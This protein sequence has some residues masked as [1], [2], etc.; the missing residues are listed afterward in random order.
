MISCGFFLG[1]CYSFF[2]LNSFP[3]TGQIHAHY[4]SIKGLTPAQRRRW[5]A[6]RRNAYRRFGL[7]AITSEVVP[8]LGMVFACANRVAYVILSFCFRLVGALVRVVDLGSFIRGRRGSSAAMWAIELEKAE[9]DSQV[10]VGDSQ[11]EKQGTF[12][13][14]AFSF[15]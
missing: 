3:R 10:I 1:N 6:Y 15:W 11:L 5:L 14:N 13:F 12:D 9:A 2:Y 4:M 8:F 7:V